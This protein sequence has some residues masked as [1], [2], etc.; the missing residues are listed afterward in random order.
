MSW[1]T[2]RWQ[3]FVALLRK[4]YLLVLRDP[5]GLALVLLAP[6]F[7]LFI[8]AYIFRVDAQAG[9]LALWDQDRSLLSR[10]YGEALVADGEM[11]LVALVQSEA[12]LERLLQAGTVD[13]GLIIPVGFGERLQ[14]AEKA[15]VQVLLD[16]TDAILAPQLAARLIGRS[17]EFSEQVL[18]RGLTLQDAPVALR[19]VVWYNPRLDTLES[20]VPGLIALVLTM[21][22]LAFALALAREHEAGVFEGL[23]NTPLRSLEYWASKALVYVSLGTLSVLGLWLL[24]V[25]YFRVPFRGSGALYLG[26]TALYLAAMVGLLMALAPLMHTQQVAFFVA[27]LYFFV[28]GFFNAGLFSP[29]PPSGLGHWV[30]EALP[31]THFIAITRGVFLKGATLAM[32]QHQVQVL[33]GM[34]GLGIGVAMASFR[35]QLL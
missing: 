10:R 7:L 30:A 9:R 5:R 21:P 2:S 6:T 13:V 24:S 11:H 18:L 29:V 28:P 14:R 19:S 27:L 26:L 31:A 3:R 15:P 32:L 12:E 34:A 1:Q 25:G 20:M 23:I 4:E 33:L 17:A 16:G 35:K 8:L 22:A